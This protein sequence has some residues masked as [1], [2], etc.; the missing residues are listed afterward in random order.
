M[1]IELT[2]EENLLGEIWLKYW[3]DGVLKKVVRI[4][5]GRG[6]DEQDMLELFKEAKAR[7]V[8]GYPKVSTVDKYA[9]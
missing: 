9:S 6:Q 2:K 4:D 7:L 3:E 5:D 8:Q 1:T